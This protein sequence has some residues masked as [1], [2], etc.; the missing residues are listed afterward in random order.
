MRWKDGAAGLRV[1][2]RRRQEVKQAAPVASM[3]RRV[4]GQGT[5]LNV[6]ARND[7]PHTMDEHLHAFRGDPERGG[8]AIS[9]VAARAKMTLTCG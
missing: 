8:Y 1:H 6:P 9:L 5:I 2:T 4:S 3:G 7:D